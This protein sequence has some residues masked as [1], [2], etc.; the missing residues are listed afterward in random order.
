MSQNLRQTF[1]HRPVSPLFLFSSMSPLWI[2]FRKMFQ[3][4]VPHWVV[5]KAMSIM[6]VIITGQILIERLGSRNWPKSSVL[7]RF[8][9]FKSIGN[10][11]FLVQ[12]LTGGTDTYK[13]CRWQWHW[14]SMHYWEQWHRQSLWSLLGRH[15][16]TDKACLIGVMVDIKRAIR[17]ALSVRHQDSDKAC[18][19]GVLETGKGCYIGDNDRH[20]YGM[21]LWCRYFW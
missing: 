8:F 14:P 5:G 19:I 4:F 12:Y 17:H 9:S 6:Y 11:Q 21:R 7:G 16:G 1:F 18:L 3:V 20:R 2:F 10:K 15:Q 13:A